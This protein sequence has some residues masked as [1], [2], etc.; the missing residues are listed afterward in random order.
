MYE[1]VY[2]TNAVLFLQF[3]IASFN[4]ITILIKE[5]INYV[6]LYKRAPWKG[7]PSR[8]SNQASGP[9]NYHCHWKSIEYTRFP[10]TLFLAYLGITRNALTT[11]QIHSSS[12][13][14][15]KKNLFFGSRNY[16]NTLYFFL[17]LNV[18]RITSLPLL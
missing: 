11:L 18:K 6:Y 2:C 5:T 16:F 10:K 4:Y 14:S 17:L 15:H 3:F 9:H 7:P 1:Y 12:K 13:G 8:R